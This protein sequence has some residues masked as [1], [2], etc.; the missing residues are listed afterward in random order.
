MA[1][2]HGGAPQDPRHGA[3]IDITPMVSG[4]D[5]S[6]R[7]LG[8]DNDGPPPAASP[9]PAPATHTPRRSPVRRV[10]LGSL[11][12]A[13]LAGAAV[14]GV[15]GW[16][17]LQQK[18]ATLRP[19]ASVGSL[20]LDQSQGAEATAENLSTA[21]AAGIDL[22]ETVAVVYADPASEERS[23]FLFG[24]TALV[25]TPERHLDDALQL[26]GEQNGSAAGMREVPPGELGGVMKCGRIQVPDVAMAA[27]GWA[28]HGS[29]AVA[30]FP[31]R[32]VAEAAELM[33]E[34]RS[35][36]QTRS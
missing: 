25:L 23:V 6:A 35:A 9:A 33:R 20:T 21:L 10:V 8:W 28:D 16:R 18:D 30:M 17:V 29:V 27:C 3:P 5:L 13:G 7:Y 32:E 36:S 12:V 22:D 26:L 2:Q 4:A 15:A 19:A 24:G 1:Q 11:L 14:V 34:L 31:G